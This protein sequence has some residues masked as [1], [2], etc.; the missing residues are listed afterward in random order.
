MTISASVVADSISLSG[1]RLTT[2]QL[3]YPRFIHSEVMTHR[4]F[5]RN[6]SSSRAIPVERLIQDVIDDPAAPI[7]WGKNQKGMQAYQEL[8][9]R[10]LAN[11][12]W[13][14]DNARESAIMH[15]KDMA[16]YGAHKQIVNR[17]LEPFAHINV[18]VT[19]TEWDNFFALR[20]HPAA[21]PE[22]AA[23]ARHMRKVM[24][25]SE[26]RVMANGDW[27]L[28]YVRQSELLEL[29]LREQTRVSAARCARVSYMTHEGREPD[30]K[31]DLLLFDRLAAEQHMSPM[32]H[33]ATPA[34][35]DGFVRNFYGWISQRAAMEIA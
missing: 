10:H 5:S 24:E 7:F 18:V 35:V 34:V 32:E 11:V 17:V 1:K 22:I 3:R 16:R 20:D 4:M 28:P 27:H 21:Q 29:T 15:A 14:W 2:L 12:K 13:F 19:A 23:L 9:G 31:G 30:V 6:A 26:P 8:E 25:M 33:Q